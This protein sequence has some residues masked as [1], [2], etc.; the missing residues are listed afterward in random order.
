MAGIL[1]DRRHLHGDQHFV[2][3][4]EYARVHGPALMAVRNSPGKTIDAASGS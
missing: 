4:D 3:D 2:F 1:K